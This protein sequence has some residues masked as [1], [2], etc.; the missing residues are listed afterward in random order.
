MYFRMRKTHALYL[1]VVLR[2]MNVLNASKL[3]SVPYPALSPFSSI[4]KSFVLRLHCL[5]ADWYSY[6]TLNS[7]S[8]SHKFEKCDYLFTVGCFLV[9]T[10]FKIVTFSKETFFSFRNNL[11]LSLIFFFF[12]WVRVGRSFSVRANFWR[13][14]VQIPQGSQGRIPNIFNF[15]TM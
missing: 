10:A 11:E 5:N 2:L 7:T 6:I 14:S 8:F 3:I 13:I 1:R 4:F 9:R 15:S 12:F